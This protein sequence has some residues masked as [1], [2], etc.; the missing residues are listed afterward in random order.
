MREP[1][2][3]LVQGR[4]CWDTLQTTYRLFLLPVVDSQFV[5]VDR[6]RSAGLGGAVK[7]EV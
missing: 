5:S 7:L 6:N 3:R 4:Q 1:L 2:S